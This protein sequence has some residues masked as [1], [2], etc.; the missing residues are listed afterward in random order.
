MDNIFFLSCFLPLV[1]A[2]YWL[3]PG[4][5]GKNAVLLVFSLLFY[6]IGSLTG[7]A[8]LVCVA[9][10]NYLLGLL[11]KHEKAKKAALTAGLVLDLGFLALFKYAD[12]VLSGILGLPPMES[13][14]AAPLGISFFIFKCISYLMDANRDGEQATKS[15]WD[16]LLYISF[17]PQNISSASSNFSVTSWQCI[18]F[19]F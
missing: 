9:L 17:F 10:V 11:L 5:K 4:I 3:V 2:A 14:L 6:S 8:L 16:F 15:F 1:L 7:L 12:F 19:P 18:H 13:G